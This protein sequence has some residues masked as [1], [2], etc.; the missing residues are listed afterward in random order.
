MFN[1][2]F[3]YFLIIFNLNLQFFNKLF[4]INGLRQIKKYYFK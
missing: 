2:F 4:L 1:F 3:I